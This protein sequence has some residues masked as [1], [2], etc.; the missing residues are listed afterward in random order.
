MITRNI[1]DC[2]WTS[3]TREYFGSAFIDILFRVWNR[4]HGLPNGRFP[5]CGLNNHSREVIEISRLDK[6]WDVYPDLAMA[7]EVMR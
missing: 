1:R 3:R 6:L 2:C 7:I 4:V 5:I